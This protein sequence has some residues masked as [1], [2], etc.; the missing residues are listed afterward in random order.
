MTSDSNI[1]VLV[2]GS[3]AVPV[4]GATTMVGGTVGE[5]LIGAQQQQ[6]INRLIPS[7]TPD[8]YSL[9]NNFSE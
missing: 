4:I 8:V 5:G 9:S 7:F 1:R 3:L 2:S 6:F